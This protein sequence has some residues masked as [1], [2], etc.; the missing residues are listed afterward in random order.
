MLA[1]VNATGLAVGVSYGLHGP[2]LPVF[3][4]DVVGA[5]YTEL[6]AIGFANFIPYMFVPLLVGAL[7]DRFANARLLAAGVAANAASVYLLSAAQSAPEIMAYRAMSGVAH[8]FFWPPCESMIAGES[9]GRDRVRNISRFTMFFVVGFM[10]GPLLGAAFLEWAGPEYR[11]LFQVTAYAMA[12]AVALALL[13]SGGRAVGRA[14]G[15]SL[16]AVA[17]MRRFPEVVVLLVFCTSC[18]GIILTIYPAYMSERGMSAVDV[19]LLYFAFGASRTASL[20]LAGRLAART[21]ATLVAATASVTAGLA[22]SVAADSLPAFAAALLLL[23]TTSS[24]RSATS[25]ISATAAALLLMGFGFSIF[26]PLTLEIVL[27]RTGRAVSGRMIG[28]YETVFGLGWAAGPAAA[29]PATELGGW[30][31]Y[32]AFCAAGACV[33][34]LAALRRGRLEPRRGH[35]V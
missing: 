27:S 21:G 2:A 19:L 20:A 15:L 17:G 11:A 10:A 1:A 33:T 31:P 7:L 24:G 29:G 22:V 14:G 6:G 8:A 23:R 13:G 30:V 25:G 3:A 34:A 12:A 28:A 26:F 32:A 16:R 5:T 9:S 35:Y 18:F 4:R